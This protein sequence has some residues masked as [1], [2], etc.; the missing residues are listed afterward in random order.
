LVAVKD[1]GFA[2]SGNRFFD[3]LD[4]EG[5]AGSGKLNRM[6]KWNFCLTAA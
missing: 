5:R 6:D 4:A 1:L 2:V 3:R